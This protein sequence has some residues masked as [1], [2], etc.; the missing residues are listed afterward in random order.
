MELVDIISIV[1][2]AAV[3]VGAVVF[4]IWLK[5]RN[6]GLEQTQAEMTAPE[7]VHARVFALNKSEALGNRKYFVHFRT[8]DERELRLSVSYDA[9]RAL[10]KKDLVFTPGKVCHQVQSGMLTYQGST[11]ISFEND[12]AE[13]SFQ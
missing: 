6:Q 12:P 9:F 11:L 1:I 3:T 4:W 5:R 7:T 2:G 8:D 13:Q 10:K